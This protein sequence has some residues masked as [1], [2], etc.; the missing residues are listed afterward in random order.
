MNRLLTI[1]TLTIGLAKSLHA[2][3]KFNWTDTTLSAG[4]TRTIQLVRA[5]SGS[6]DSKPCYEYADNKLTY[7]TLVSFLKANKE[8]S[9]A[10]LWH[11]WTYDDS[12][13]NLHISKKMTEGLIKELIR[14]GID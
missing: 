5:F 14:Q 1:L 6:C 3:E 13:Y 8:I 10:F 9:L 12:D 4:Q 2:Q 11:T 7:D